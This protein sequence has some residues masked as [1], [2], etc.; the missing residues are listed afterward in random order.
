[1]EHTWNSQQTP[2][3]DLAKQRMKKIFLLV[4][5]LFVLTDLPIVWLTYQFSFRGNADVSKN[6][7]V[8]TIQSGES[9]QM[10]SRRLKEEGVI[11]SSILFRQYAK[12]TRRDNT[13]RPGTYTLP[14]RTSI[15]FA[16]DTLTDTRSQER[17]ITLLEGWTIRD[18]GEY[19]VEKG[20]VTSTAAWYDV[21]GTPPGPGKKLVATPNEFIDSFGA[22]LTYIF[23]FGEATLEGFLFPDTYRIRSDATAQDIAYMM[24]QTYFKKAPR[25]TF[26][27]PGE[28]PPDGDVFDDKEYGR[29]ILAS[30]LEREVRSDEDRRKVADLFQRRLKAGMALQADSTVNYITGKKIASI[31]L[32]D[33][34][35]DSLWNTYKYPGL[36]PTPISNPSAS[37]IQAVLNPE[38]NDAWYFLTDDEG[39]VHYATTHD[40][41]VANKNRYLK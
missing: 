22:D 6:T 17:T 5:I 19:L 4:A 21:V 34:D 24:V 11:G 7:V 12:W 18:M 8:F 9:A 10:V 13:L 2:N 41:H 38:P 20:A 37:A 28:E 14:E 36:P 35:I 1:M 30:I 39:T 3:P 15:L 23:P 27:L 33:R 32:D 16:I 29:I 26:S 31:T 25:V 40:E